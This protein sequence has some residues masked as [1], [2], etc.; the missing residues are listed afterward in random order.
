MNANP[1][2]PKSS[3]IALPPRGVATRSIEIALPPTP[4]EYILEVT[5]EGAEGHVLA[6]RTVRRTG[7]RTDGGAGA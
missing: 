5:A 7:D 4:G 1:A 3:P 2:T 6:R